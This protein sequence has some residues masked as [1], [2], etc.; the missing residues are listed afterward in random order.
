VGLKGYRIG[1]AQIS[2]RHANFIVNCGQA[3]ANDIYRLI[4]LAQEKV[5]QQWSIL[6]EP[7]VRILGS[8]IA[9]S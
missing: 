5:Y 6:M 8:F 3:S 2:E 9:N 7:E 4:R 1:G